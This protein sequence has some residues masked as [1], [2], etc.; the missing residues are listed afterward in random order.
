MNKLQIGF[1]AGFVLVLCLFFYLLNDV[2]LPFVIGFAL[3]YFLDPVADQ[4][5]KWGVPRG[6]ATLLV[7]FGFLLVL[8]TIG[9]AFWPILADQASS[10]IKN[11][12]QL[13]DKA[14]NTLL[15]WVD[16]LMTRVSSMTGGGT[17]EPKTALAG[18]ADKGGQ[19]M[20]GFITGILNQGLALFNLLALLFVT[21]V[22]AFFLL[23][24]WDL[25]VARIDSWLP[26]QH[27]ETVRARAREI[28]YVLSGYLRGQALV[29]II[30]AAMYAIGWSIV[31]LHYA[32]LLAVVGGVLAFLPYVGAAITV[33]LAVAI[34]IGQ[35]WPDY[36]SVGMVFGVYVIVQSLEGN[37]IT[38][39]L[40]G[41]RVG[42]SALWVIFAMMAGGSLLGILGILLAVPVA[43]ILGVLL[44]AGL[45]RYKDSQL[46]SD[47][48][49]PAPPPPASGDPA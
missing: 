42:L 27:A 9:L 39:K 1:W 2:L 11:L 20:L 32:L 44:R 14:L 23:R 22:V 40:V 46:Y 43:A 45:K 34:G 3:A 25:I 31:G 16:N 48:T 26:R 15:P 21:P 47:D 29:A 5:E 37:F 7:L 28:D 19:W 35:F 8:L 36:L 17:V 41:D 12:P 24:D 18:I 38:P 6:L 13:I 33:T 30:L 4:I 49:Q 10:F